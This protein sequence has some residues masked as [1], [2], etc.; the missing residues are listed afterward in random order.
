VV[1][2]VKPVSIVDAVAEDIRMSIFGGSLGGGALLTEAEIATRYEVARPTAKAAI[3][4]LVAEG[5]LQ[6]GS[7]RTARV[8]TLGEE[9]VAD[10][11][12]SR[13]CI[14]IQVVR[15]LAESS[16]VPPAA[17]KADS[18]ALAALHND[19]EALEAGV[20][21]LASIEPIIRFHSSLVDALGSP[22]FSRLFSSLIGEMRLCMVQMGSQ[23]LL[24]VESVV[25]E[26][27]AITDRIA[28]GDVEGAAEALTA[29]LTHGQARLLD[30]AQVHAAV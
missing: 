25:S 22:R 19:H 21:P 3:E 4:K 12:F 11:Y 28:D 10:L 8:P 18:E 29:H 17:L 16:F 9:D 7:H 27:R 2:R 15:Q 13:R 24:R 5:L 1:N 26:H 30:S 23:S 14:E 6:R 20:T